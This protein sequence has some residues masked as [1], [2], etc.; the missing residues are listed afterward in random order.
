MHAKHFLLLLI[1]L[2]KEYSNYACDILKADTTLALVPCQG[3]GCALRVHYQLPPGQST[4]SY[5]PLKQPLDQDEHLK[6]DEY[7]SQHA[8]NVKYTLQFKDSTKNE[9]KYLIHVSY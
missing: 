1:G 6:C 5:C 7:E 8:V 9:Y 2:S 3:Q 4:T